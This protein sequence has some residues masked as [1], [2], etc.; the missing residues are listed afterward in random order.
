LP[1]EQMGKPGDAL[2]SCGTEI[3][4]SACIRLVAWEN[5]QRASRPC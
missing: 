3:F 4:T 5:C 1:F 2:A